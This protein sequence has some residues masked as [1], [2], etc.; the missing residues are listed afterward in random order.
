LCAAHPLASRAF[1]GKTDL[2]L[3]ACSALVVAFFALAQKLCKRKKA[4]AFQASSPKT[5]QGSVFGP[6]PFFLARV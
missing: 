3:R 4:A 5:L 2:F 1:R 6:A